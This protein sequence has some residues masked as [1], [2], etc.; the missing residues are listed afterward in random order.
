MDKPTLILITGFARA[1]KDTLADGIVMG[2]SGS[3]K[4]LRRNFA[5]ALKDAGNNFLEDIGLRSTLVDFKN[6]AFKVRHRDMLVALGAGA[7][8][9]NPSVFA[10]LFVDTCLEFQIEAAPKGKNPLVIASDWRYVNELKVPQ[11]RLAGWR[12]V[13]VMIDT[14]GVGA[15]NEEEGLSVG[16]ITR[17][18]APDFCYAFRPDSAHKIYAEGKQ[19]AARLGL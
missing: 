5:C 12:I 11:A 2:S 4:I 10:D 7:R 6:D 16:Q 13:T 14:A 18:I 9:I 1:G 3:F 17:E 19:L 15:A 8:S